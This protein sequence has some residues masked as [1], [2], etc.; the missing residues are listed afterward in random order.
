M[1]SLSVKMNNKK[2]FLKKEK[3]A[4]IFFSGSGCSDEF[5]RLK[6]L[7]VNGKFGMRGSSQDFAYTVYRLENSCIL[8]FPTPYCGSVLC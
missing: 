3:R 2:Q 1:A 7:P 6:N 8:A 4:E 5:K